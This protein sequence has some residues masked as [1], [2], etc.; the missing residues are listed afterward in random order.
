MHCC[1]IILQI[2]IKAENSQSNLFQ[3]MKRMN[4]LMIWNKQAARYLSRKDGL[5]KIKRELLFKVYNHGKPCVSPAQNGKNTVIES[6]RESGGCINKEAMAFHWLNPC[7]ER[8][9]VF[10][11]SIGLSLHLLSSP[12]SSSSLLF[13]FSFPFVFFFFKWKH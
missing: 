8:R 6:Q 9:G 1:F 4:N 10:L 12:H 13:Y 2:L 5:Y 11:L 7:Q 3:R